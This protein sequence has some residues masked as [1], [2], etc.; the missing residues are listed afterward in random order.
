MAYRSRGAIEASKYGA[1]AALVRSVAPYSLYTPHTGT[2][3]LRTNL[4]LTTYSQ[5]PLIT[6][7]PLPAFH[8]RLLQ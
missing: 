8:L 2:Y 5:E 3:S 7:P 1:V 4:Y 6:M